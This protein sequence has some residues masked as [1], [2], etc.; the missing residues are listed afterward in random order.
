MEINIDI[1]ILYTMV[2][3]SHRICQASTTFNNDQPDL[4]DLHL[5]TSCRCLWP[6]Q[7]TLKC[8]RLD[9]EFCIVSEAP[10]SATVTEAVR[11]TK[12][13]TPAATVIQKRNLWSW[14]TKH[15]F[16]SYSTFY[17]I[18]FMLMGPF[19]SVLHLAQ[20]QPPKLKSWTYLI[21]IYWLH[22]IVS[23]G[24]SLG[25]SLIY[26]HFCFVFSL[27]IAM[28]MLCFVQAPSGPVSWLLH[29][30]REMWHR[31]KRFQRSDVA[32]CRYF[33]RSSKLIQLVRPACEKCAFPQYQEA[34]WWSYKHHRRHCTNSNPFR[35]LS[36]WQVYGPSVSFHKGYKR[37]FKRY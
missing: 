11:G 2:N 7:M 28:P 22:Y 26:L 23:L 37:F 6:Q 29:L 27:P 36:D 30:G 14:W 18:L 15:L 25:V 17:V 9:W 20:S 16:L 8:S 35:I 32:W 31:L 5:I 24:V 13:C 10:T 1:Q 34:A 3:M 21:T 4:N 12:V 19:K 33:Q